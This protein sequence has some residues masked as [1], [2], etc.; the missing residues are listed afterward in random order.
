[1]SPTAIAE[2]KAFAEKENLQ[3]V[4]RSTIVSCPT[5]SSSTSRE[6]RNLAYRCDRSATKAKPKPHSVSN[7]NPPGKLRNELSVPRRKKWRGVFVAL[8]YL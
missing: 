3:G 8:C 4:V 2:A 1:M 5:R 7:T 6:L